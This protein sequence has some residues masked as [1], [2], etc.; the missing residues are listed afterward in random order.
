MDEVTHGNP[1]WTKHCAAF[2]VPH[3]NGAS[4]GKRPEAPGRCLCI[5]WMGWMDATEKHMTEPGGDGD[6]VLARVK[7]TSPEN[8]G[9]Y[10]TY[11]IIIIY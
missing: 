10:M 8:G 9:E 5:R 6:D 1:L 4:E 11:F 3:I 7:T 2:C